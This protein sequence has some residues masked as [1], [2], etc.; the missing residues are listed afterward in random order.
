MSALVPRER[1][2]Q[3][4]LIIRGH[5]VMLDADLA[6]LYGV[7]TKAFNRAVTRNMERFPDD[8]MFRLTKKEDE[9]LRYH[10]GTS[11]WGGRRYLPYAFTE[12][13]VGCCQVSFG[14][15]VPE[16]RLGMAQCLI[17]TEAPALTF[18]ALKG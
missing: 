10:F 14:M 7:E 5:R 18:I 15:N 16:P 8:F 1:I 9:D 4:I 13:G 6:E 11:R 3:T 17:G 12:Q 2:E